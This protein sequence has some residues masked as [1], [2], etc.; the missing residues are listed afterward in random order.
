[1][2]VFPVVYSHGISKVFTDI[3]SWSNIIT[4]EKYGN[5]SP[6]CLVELIKTKMSQ[7]RAS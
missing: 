2:F 3:I 1:M 6:S 5:K 7:I 4:G